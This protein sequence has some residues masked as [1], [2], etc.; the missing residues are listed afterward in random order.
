[1][2]EKRIEKLMIDFATHQFDILV[3]TTIVESGLDF[4]EAN[5]IVIDR[6]D[7]LGLAQLY[8]LRGR[9]GRSKRRAYCYLLVPP[10][11]LLTADARKRLA[12][13]RT[14]TE[15]GS[16]YK[17]AARDLEIRGA[18][19]L[20]GPEQSGQIGAVGF[21]MYTQLL[22]QEI[23]R[24]KGEEVV[25]PFECE[26][27]MQVPA[28]LPENYVSDVHLRLNLYKRISDARDDAE[29][30][31]LLAEITDRFGRPPAPVRHLLRIVA[32]RRRAEKLRIKKIEAGTE[33]IAFELDET[34]PVHP[35]R[36]VQLIA[37]QPGRF[38]LSPDGKLYERTGG[39]DIEAVFG[40]LE[41]GL[42]RL[43]DCV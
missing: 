39:G 5:T 19:N 13:L 9:V 26:V 23:K 17:I 24:L 32:L 1:M 16:G 7:A 12:V 18:G 3:C 15:L 14:F 25:E 4:P 36:M 6:A 2:D 27:S 21:E 35:A 11:G 8:Q 41:E 20:L 43:A 30:E 34:T 31:S 42:Q 38:S 40:A 29:I 22:E 37:A 33:R 28:Y 10:T